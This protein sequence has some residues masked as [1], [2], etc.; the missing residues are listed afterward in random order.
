MAYILQIDTSG[1]EGRVILAADGVPVA[2]EINS[3]SRDHA[4]AINSMTEKV[5]SAAGIGLEHIDAIAVCAG[6]GSYTGLRIG[7]A[8]AKGFCYALD[9]PLLLQNK[10]TLLAWQ[11]F[12]RLKNENNTVYKR[13]ISILTA[14][15]KE[16]FTAT[17][18]DN[19]N[20]VTNPVHVTENEL[21]EEINKNSENIY[22]TGKI[23]PEV[24]K[25]NI[26]AVYYHEDE[27]ID[28]GLWAQYVFM[29]YKRHEFVVLS[30]SEPFYLKQVFINK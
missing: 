28:A 10:L 13:I 22:V 18:D 7:L 27:Y 11:A 19:F 24:F 21:L 29:S 9:K 26:Y 15:E 23:D 20:T 17:Y 14:R 16:Y 4:A 6:P 1:N 8:T 3:N 25:D 30:T 12:N 5:L 2:T